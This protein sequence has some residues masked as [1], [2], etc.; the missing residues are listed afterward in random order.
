MDKLLNHLD[1]N[2]SP[3]VMLIKLNKVSAIIYDDHFS[4]LIPGT[5]KIH[6]KDDKNEYDFP[7]YIDKGTFGYLLSPNKRVIPV[8]LNDEIKMDYLFYCKSKDA[9][10]DLSMEI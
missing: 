2:Y 4:R 3:Y 7:D 9:Y 5:G 6:F 1:E 8:I 10:F